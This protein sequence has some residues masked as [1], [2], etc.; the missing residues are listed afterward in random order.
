MHCQS[1]LTAY[2]SQKTV[3]FEIDNEALDL[4]DERLKRAM[5][6]DMRLKLKSCE[7]YSFIYYAQRQ[8]HTHTDDTN[9]KN[10]HKCY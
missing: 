10:K 2:D 8:H 5:R 6:Y 4:F 1:Q 7:Y 3:L 9:E